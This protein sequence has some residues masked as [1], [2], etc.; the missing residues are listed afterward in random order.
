MIKVTLNNEILKYIIEIEKNRY[1]LSTVN[2]SLSVAN[3]L[4]KHSKK[5]SSYASTKI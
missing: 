1:K 3:K 5:K 4:R 2:I